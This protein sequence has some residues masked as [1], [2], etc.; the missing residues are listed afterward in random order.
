MHSA[1]VGKCDKS[2]TKDNQLCPHKLGW[3]WQ[4]QFLTVLNDYVSMC[5]VTIRNASDSKWTG[6]FLMY[7]TGK[8]PEGKH[9]NK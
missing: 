7:G 2:V 4:Q 1:R 3:N 5:A 8:E 9:R 6:T